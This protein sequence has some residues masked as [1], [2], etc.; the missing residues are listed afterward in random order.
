[1]G[2]KTFWTKLQEERAKAVLDVVSDLED[3]YPLTLR[4]IHYRLVE[5]QPLWYRSSINN[6]DP[7]RNTIANYQALSQVLKWMRIDESL[8]WEVLTDRVRRVSTKRGFEDLQVFINQEMD[9]FLEGYDRCLVQSQDIYLEL[10]VEKDALSAVFEDVADPFC[11]RVV[12]RRGYN[13]ITFEADYYRRAMEAIKKKQEPVVLYFGDFD[14]SG[15]DMLRASLETLRR[16]LGLTQL[17]TV[18]VALTEEQALRLPPKP[19]AA[20][21]GDTRYK[22]FYERHPNVPVGSAWELDALHPRELSRIARAAIM[23]AL[24]MD[25]FEAE[26]EQEEKDR[27]R[28]HQ[29]RTKILKLVQKEVRH[30]YSSMKTKG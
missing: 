20:K 22:S 16:E 28:L 13:S 8:P 26:Q 19:D 23:S 29:L 3:Y 4:Q 5:K 18:P 17:R 27:A 10:W 7:Y 9:V 2:T 30:F 14:P 1:M 11:L 6:P 12:T 21:K 15:E 25:S 24:D